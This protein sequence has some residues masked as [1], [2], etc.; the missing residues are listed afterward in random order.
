MVNCIEYNRNIGIHY[1]NVGVYAIHKITPE[2]I[3][4]SV[5]AKSY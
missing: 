4:S 2:S 3:Y 1:T 5:F